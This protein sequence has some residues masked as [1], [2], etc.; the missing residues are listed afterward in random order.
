MA[1]ACWM[2]SM[3]SGGIGS[4][5]RP[6]A[7]PPVRL[8]LGLLFDFF[9]QRLDQIGFPH[10]FTERRWLA[11][12]PCG[13]CL[14]RFRERGD[15]GWGPCRSC[16][17]DSRN[18]GA[19]LHERATLSRIVG[20]AMEREA[21]A[22]SRFPSRLRANRRGLPPGVLLWCTFQSEHVVSCFASGGSR[23]GEDWFWVP[24]PLQTPKPN[25]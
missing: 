12:H 17:M 15:L 11:S 24:Y 9:C 4:R 7:H 20:F 14:E 25:S 18:N 8:C 16:T 2:C 21:A 5:L 1:K 19:G 22:I 23:A 6:I 13:D 3:S 10:L